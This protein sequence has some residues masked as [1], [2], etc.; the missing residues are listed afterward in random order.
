MAAARNWMLSSAVALAASGVAC[1]GK[2]QQDPGSWFG[3]AATFGGATG[4]QLQLTNPGGG[5]NATEGAGANGTGGMGDVPVSRIFWDTGSLSKPA[6][7]LCQNDICPDGQRCF[8][9]T[10]E[11]GICG[12]VAFPKPPN[13]PAQAP[14]PLRAHEPD[15]CGCDDLMCP[16]DQACR[17]VEEFCSCGRRLHN[18]CI[19]PLCVS[20]A[21]CGDDVCVPTPLMFYKRC[22]TPQ[23]RRDADCTERPGGACV[24][25]IVVPNQSG[26]PWLKGLICAYPD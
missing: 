9:M 24:A 20:D 1:G 3:G 11:F 7:S 22:V 25:Q 26:D 15:E 8:R 4:G 23:C 10:D 6:I 18:A 5:G 19:E 21:D 12:D 16:A 17:T 14:E 13:C 2:A